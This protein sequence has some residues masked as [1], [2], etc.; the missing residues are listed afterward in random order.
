MN[1]D[2]MAVGT[3]AQPR[4]DWLHWQAWAQ[5]Q[6]QRSG[7]VRCFCDYTI[8]HAVYEPPQG[9]RPSASIRYAAET[10]WLIMRGEAP[11]KKNGGSRQY[12]GNAQ[13]L[14]EHEE[15]KGSTFSFGDRYVFDAARR[16]GGPGTP[17]TWITAGINH[18]VTLTARQVAAL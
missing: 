8:Q 1:L 16:S 9:G 12:Y 15:F 11:S 13:L 3:R 6:D 18:H 14:C 4:Y 7:H 2:G 10:Y 17:A 5:A